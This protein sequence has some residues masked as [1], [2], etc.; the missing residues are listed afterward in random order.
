[1]L[2]ANHIS[3]SM[4][5]S[6]HGISGSNTSTGS[7]GNVNISSF[8]GSSNLTAFSESISSRLGSSENNLTAA[9]ISGSWEGALGANP[10][11]VVNSA[12]SQISGAFAADSA[13]IAS[14]IS[15]NVSNIAANSSTGTANAS[16]ITTL[17]NRDINSG[18]GISGGGD[19]SAD[20][21]LAVDFTD[22]TL[23]SNI[24]GAFA[25]D[26]SSLAGRVSTMEGDA[27]SAQALGTTSSPTFAGMNIS[28]DLVAQ[29]YIV[30]SSVT[31]FTQSFSSGSTGFGDSTDDKHNFTGS[32]VLS[33]SASSPSLT[34]TTQIKVSNDC[35]LYTSPSPRDRG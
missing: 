12:A 19:L 35:L 21:T 2:R 33:G 23:Q 14:S 25:S 6:S 29:R 4:I 18:V 24:S 17:Q 15:T 22:S 9:N 31:H 11:A 7:F 20:R 13:S 5:T 34:A 26:S 3:A 10:A 8:A 16:A 28:G 27:A 30:S 32:I 1:M